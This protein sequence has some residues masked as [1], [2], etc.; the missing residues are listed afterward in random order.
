M[1]F[2]SRLGMPVVFIVLFIGWVLYRLIYKK[3]LKNNLGTLYTGVIFI[4][5]W[6]LIYWC[7]LK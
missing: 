4:I 6:G 7:F 2:F 3:D 1:I 5:V